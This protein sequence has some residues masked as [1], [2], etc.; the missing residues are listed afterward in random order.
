[1]R[2]ALTA[3]ALLACAAPAFAAEAETDDIVSAMRSQRTQYCSISAEFREFKLIPAAYGGARVDRKGLIAAAKTV[4]SEASPDPDEQCAVALT[5]FNRA[6]DGEDTLTQVVTS[7]GQF[8]GYS[9]A[10][11]RECVKLK[12]AVAAVKRLAAGER[13]SFGHRRFMYFC[14]AEAWNHVKK[15]RKAGS[16]QAEIIGETAFLVGGPC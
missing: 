10:D 16:E 15:K 4:F 2:A 8:E 13:C 11:R 5:I 9:S 14:S 3:A 6:R 1:M 12:G 7:P